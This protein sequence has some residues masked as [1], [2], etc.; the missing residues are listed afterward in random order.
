ML[1][2]VVH[3]VCRL[4]TKAEA[5]DSSLDCQETHPESA[6]VARPVGK[7]VANCQGGSP[8]AGLLTACLCS[9]IRETSYPNRATLQGCTS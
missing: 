7:R 1:A 3:K 5:L 9:A 4:D 2:T 6:A 8:G